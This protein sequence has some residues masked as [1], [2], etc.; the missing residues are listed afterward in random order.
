MIPE[1]FTLLHLSLMELVSGTKATQQVSTPLVVTDAVVFP[2]CTSIVSAGFDYQQSHFY[3]AI[4][5]Q[6]DAYG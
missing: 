1:A 2:T 4:A 3:W 5:A 6:I